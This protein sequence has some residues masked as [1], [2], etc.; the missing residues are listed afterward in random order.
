[1]GVFKFYLDTDALNCLSGLHG[2]ELDEFRDRFNS[3][4][5]ELVITHVQIDERMNADSLQERGR[6]YSDIVSK[7]VKTLRDNGI[8]VKVENPKISVV[9]IARV[10]YCSASN[11]AVGEVYDELR[12]KICA[13]EASR[14]RRSRPKDVLNIARDAVIAV[15]AFEHSYLVTTDWCLSDSFNKVIEEKKELV[16]KVIMP[17]AKFVGQ[18]PRAVADCIL[19]SFHEK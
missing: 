7:A 9:G 14:H 2:K 17:K 10:G 12:K 5:A 11:P 16:E 19:E 1:M 18:S 6:K 8:N 15:S 4:D 13:C 3:I